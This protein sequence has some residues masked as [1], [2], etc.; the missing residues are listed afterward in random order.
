MK[1]YGFQLK[2]MGLFAFEQQ[3]FIAFIKE[4]KSQAN[5]ELYGLGS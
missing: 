3:G 5:K 1:Q 4:K 2:Y